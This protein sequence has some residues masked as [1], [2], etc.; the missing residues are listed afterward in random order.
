MGTQIAYFYFMKNEAD[1]IRSVV[2]LH[3]EYWEKRNLPKYTGGPFADRTGGLIA[4]E[5]KNIEEA[6]GIIKN[7][8]FVLEGLIEGS[9]I[10]EWIVE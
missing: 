8:P 4:F 2:P 6:T 5:A 3:V 10:K 1:R 7:D 9:W